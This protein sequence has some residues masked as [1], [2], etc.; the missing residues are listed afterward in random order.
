M[1]LN[2]RIGEMSLTAM[3]REGLQLGIG[4]KKIFHGLDVHRV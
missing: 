3:P 1:S 4:E 2:G